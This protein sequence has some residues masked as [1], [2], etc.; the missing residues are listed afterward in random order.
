MWKPFSAGVSLALLP[1]YLKEYGSCHYLAGFMVTRNLGVIAYGKKFYP[2][3]LINDLDRLIERNKRN[4]TV[5]LHYN[6]L[7]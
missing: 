3:G 6:A 5:T 4:K 2:T 1:I 7:F